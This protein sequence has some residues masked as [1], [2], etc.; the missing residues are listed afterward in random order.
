[1]LNTGT[2]CSLTVLNRNTSDNPARNQV[3]VYDQDVFIGIVGSRGKLKS[4]YLGNFKQGNAI[5][6]YDIA[7]NPVV[8][9]V[10]GC[11]TTIP[12]N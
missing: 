11:P 9:D 4:K 6:V 7:G 12:A 3:L 2:L 1:M 10:M 5:F 8:D